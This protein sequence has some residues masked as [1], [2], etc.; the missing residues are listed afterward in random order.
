MTDTDDLSKPADLTDVLKQLTKVI[1]DVETLQI[2]R[3][4]V[5]GTRS[6][7]T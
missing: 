1:R 2:P 3:S 7:W 4:N 6:T 5:S